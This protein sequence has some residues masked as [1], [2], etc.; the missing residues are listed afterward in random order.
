[1]RA[2]WI[3]AVSSVPLSSGD[4]RVAVSVVQI[5]GSTGSAGRLESLGQPVTP[6]VVVELVLELEV[7]LVPELVLPLPPREVADPVTADP[8]APPTLDVVA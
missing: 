1:L 7:V 3:R 8:V 2:D 5:G 6:P 4:E